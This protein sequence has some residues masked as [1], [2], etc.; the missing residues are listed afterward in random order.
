MISH[1]FLLYNF[2][3]IAVDGILKTEFKIVSI[4]MVPIIQG[5]CI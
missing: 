2:T 3:A 1:L 5:E 4:I